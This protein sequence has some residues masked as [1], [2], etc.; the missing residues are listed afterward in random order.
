MRY[1]LALKEMK[2]CQFLEILFC[3]Y[4][5][6]TFPLKN[7]LRPWV[8]QSWFARWREFFLFAGLGLDYFMTGKINL[9]R[10]LKPADEDPIMEGRVT[11]VEKS[12]KALLETQEK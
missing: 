8:L 1:R 7:F 3:V 2:Y 4:E 9:E 5:S 6:E 10:H 11:Q 12:G